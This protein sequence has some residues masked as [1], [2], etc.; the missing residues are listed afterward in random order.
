MNLPST[1]KSLAASTGLSAADR[2]AIRDL[3]SIYHWALDTADVETLVDTFVEDGVV[4]LHTWRTH[5]RYEGRMGLMDLAE[6]LW[7]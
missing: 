1:S 5:T 7:S 6:S 4:E 2:F 3:F